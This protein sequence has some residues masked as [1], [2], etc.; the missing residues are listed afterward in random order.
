R[1][2]RGKATG[3]VTDAKLRALEIGKAR[4]VR[5]GSGVAFLVFGTLLGTA[6]KVAEA[7]GATLVDMRFVKPLDEA[8]ILQMAD[9]HELL[10]TVEENVVA[11][12][13]GSGV[14]E[15][16]LAQG[17]RVDVL[18]LGLPDR[19]VAHGKVPELHA[20]C[21]LD[22]AGILASV[23]VRLDG[24]GEGSGDR[25]RWHGHE[26][27]CPEAVG[28][29]PPPASRSRLP[30]LPDPGPWQGR[31]HQPALPAQVH[32][33]R[34]R[35]GYA[36]HRQRQWRSGA[37]SGCRAGGAD[38]RLWPGALFQRHPQRGA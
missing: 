25:H 34:P 33:R 3:C 23:R 31:H 16:L 13:A 8:L 20:A 27:A 18:N 2:P 5:E 37:G 10:V 17:R 1:Y 29:L 15:F 28:S 30:R 36:R 11:G 4:V 26:V 38:P 22:V 32:R 19:F 7:L 14:N 9:S 12:G 6:D 21:G 24:H 35:R